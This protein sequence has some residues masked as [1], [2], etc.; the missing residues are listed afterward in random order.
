MDQSELD[1]KYFLDAKTYNCPFCKRGS[2]GYRVLWATSFNWSHD[3]TAYLYIVRCNSCAKESLHLS[4]TDFENA[5]SSGFTSPL[6]DD[7]Q[8]IVDFDEETLDEWF[9]YHQ[10][11]S[12]FTVD[13][14]IP[15]KIRTLITEAEGCR[16]MNYLVGGSGALRKAIYEFLD[17]QEAEGDTYEDRIKWLKTKYPYIPS[18]YFDIL[19]NVQDMTSENLHEQQGS[20]ESWDNKDLRL[21]VTTAKDILQEVYVRPAQNQETLKEVLELKQKSTSFQDK[22]DIKKT[23]AQIKP[24]TSK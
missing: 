15:E 9:F 1:K 10:P 3:K 16:K 2:V 17:E 23:K 22:S 11:T 8:D 13:S 24:Q 12:F 7:A 19:A 18:E 4:Y 21:L 20:W 6:D 14:R 5:Q